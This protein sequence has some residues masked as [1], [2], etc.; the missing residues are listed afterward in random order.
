M[1]DSNEPLTITFYAG[2]YGE[3]ASAITPLCA[4]IGSVT[5]DGPPF[6]LFEEIR[7]LL[8]MCSDRY[9][10]LLLEGPAL[11]VFIGRKQSGTVARMMRLNIVVKD[12]QARTGV[13]RAEAPRVDSDL[14]V[15]SS[16]DDV[17]TI[18]RIVL[19]GLVRGQ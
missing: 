3:D 13:V 8:A 16:D 19:E 17:A 14:V 9:S 1:N 5:R 10:T 15:V 7:C 4:V 11:T 6:T 2:E 18:V 12:G